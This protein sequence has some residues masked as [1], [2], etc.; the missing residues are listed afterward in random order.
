[1]LVFKID[2]LGFTILELLFG[3]AIFSTLCLLGVEMASVETIKPHQQRLQ[4]EQTV[5][6]L[7]L[8]RLDSIYTQSNSSIRL[9]DNQLVAEIPGQ[10]ALILNLQAFNCEANQ[11]YFGFNHLGNARY[12][13]TIFL[14]RAT[15][16]KKIVFGV[17]AQPVR[18]VF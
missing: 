13:G 4:I 1:M 9:I 7:N 12:A 3:L 14:D 2:N 8:L 11:N 10:T 17:G 15:S 16:G 18:A 5:N 6:G